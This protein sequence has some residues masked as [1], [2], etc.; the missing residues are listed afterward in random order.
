MPKP[1]LEAPPETPE[2]YD[3]IPW[4]KHFEEDLTLDWSEKSPGDNPL[5]VQAWKNCGYPKMPDETPWCGIYMGDLLLRAGILPPKECA[6]ARN[7][8]DPDWA[9]GL[10]DPMYGCIVNIERNEPGG[11]SHVGVCLSWDEDYVRLGGGNQSNTVTDNLIVK[12]SRVISYKLPV[13]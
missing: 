3:Q 4:M 2:T 5:I 1:K 7:Y 12:R 13:R 8:S 10:S 11:D 6:W 9:I